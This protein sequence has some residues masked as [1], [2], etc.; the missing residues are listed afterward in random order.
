MP[1]VRESPP[2]RLY[3][4]D[5]FQTFKRIS[6]ASI[7][8]VLCDPPYGTTACKWDSVIP[9]VEM[10]EELER[11]IKPVN[12]ICIMATE[13]FTSKLINSN[14]QL[15]KYR[16]T[17]LKSK[18]NGIVNAKLRPLKVVEDICVFSKGATANGS[19]RN[20][21]Y[22]PQGLKKLNKTVS[23]A[24][25]KKGSGGTDYFRENQPET[26]FQEWTNYPKD[27]IDIPSEG[28]IY[29]HPTEKPFKLMAYL[30]KTFTLP[31]ETV[32]D[33]TM[34]SGTTGAAA[35]HL[36]RR[37]IG[38]DSD[39][40]NGYFETASTRIKAAYLQSKKLFS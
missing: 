32:L 29:G 25:E 10:W 34:G 27:L 36:G 3:N 19:D 20:M 12:A 28:L 22:Y 15:F 11:I 26:H 4:E 8:L 37:F 9:L 17:W 18:V 30:I 33:F 23:K 40:K 24:K 13:P 38:C 7:D 35:M 31:G 16:L 2:Y 21:V 14:L 5:C 39:T 1:S 6:D